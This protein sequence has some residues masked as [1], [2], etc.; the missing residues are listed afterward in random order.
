MKGFYGSPTEGKLGI[1]GDIAKKLFK[2]EPKT[3]TLQGEKPITIDNTTVEKGN[4]SYILKN[5]NGDSLATLSFDAAGARQNADIHKGLITLAKKYAQ[6]EVQE[7][8]QY[9]ID[10]TPELKEQVEEGLPL[11]HYNDKGEI[12]GFTHNG[13]IYLNGEKITA[14]TTMEEAGHIWTNWA[15]ENSVDLYKAG[16]NKVKGSKYLS[17]VEANKN[18]QKE[19]L[20]LGKKGSPAYNTYMREEAL[21]KAIADN[22]AKFV[23]ETRKND[24]IQWVNEMW[25]QVAQAFGIRNLSTNEI[26]A[27][28]LEEFAKRAAADVFARDQFS[29]NI[30]DIAEETGLSPQEV[31]RTYKKY[32][33]SKAIEDI[34]IDDYLAARATGDKVKLEATAKAFDALLQAENAETS[35]S[36]SAKKNAE[37]KMKEADEKALKEA[38]RI[39]EHI[40]EI[41]SKLQENG[42][43][44]AVHCKWGK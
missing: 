37:K 7:T 18:Y 13:K 40:D 12:L 17:D 41:R 11:F 8:A 15:K 1:I 3:T 42:V 10:I 33:G 5:E 4:Q 9:S 43:I 35:V 25:K 36:P 31:E 22:G 27:L 29:D 24:F 21:A 26:K 2:Q 34:T 30:L 28:S 38:A 14:K 19:A 32:E 20:K 16:L 6:K 39:M 23:T 44:E